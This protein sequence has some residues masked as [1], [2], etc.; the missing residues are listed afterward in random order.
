MCSV[1]GMNFSAYSEIWRF[2]A[3]R[4]AVLLGV[5][6]KA[7]WFG[8]MVV[9]TLHVVGDLGHGLFQV[10]GIAGIDDGQP[11]HGPHHGQ[12]AELR[13]GANPDPVRRL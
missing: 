9:L 1:G 8:V 3:V 6:G 2:P 4:Q 5:L 11:R 10:Q 12:I 7:P 13:T